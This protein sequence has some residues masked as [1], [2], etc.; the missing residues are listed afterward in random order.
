AQSYY[1]YINSKV[2]E[3]IDEMVVNNILDLNKFNNLDEFMKDKV[4]EEIIRPYYPDNLYLINDNHI[5]EI[6]KLINSDKPNIELLLPADIVV[7]KEYD[8]LI[9]NASKTNVESYDEILKDEVKTPLGTIKLI[10]K[11]SED[12]SNYIIRI[13]SKDVNLPLHVRTRKDGDKIAVKNMTGTKKVNDIFIDSKISKDDRNIYPIITDS[14]DKVI[15]IPGI[16][17]SNLDIPIN[18]EYDIIIKYVREEYN[19][20]D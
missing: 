7:K 5:V 11:D 17:K 2:Y 18:E 13:N 20:E 3:N 14:N 6:L 15:F 10:D 8:K 9:I 19:E 12:T 4:L 16:K 1:D